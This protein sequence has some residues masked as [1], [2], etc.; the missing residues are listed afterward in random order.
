M[1]D[2]AQE[3]LTLMIETGLISLV[4]FAVIGVLIYLEVKFHD[5]SK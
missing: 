1:I 5:F 2:K 4:F 3:F